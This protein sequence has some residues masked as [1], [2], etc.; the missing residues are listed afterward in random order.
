L[1]VDRL[2][3]AISPHKHVGED[4]SI[5]LL[6]PASPVED[7]PWR[8][9]TF[10][11]CCYDN[12]V[13]NADIAIHADSHLIEVL[14]KVRWRRM[15]GRKGNVLRFRNKVARWKRMDKVGGKNA[16]KYRRVML[17]CQPLILQR[18]E[19]GA[20]L[21]GEYGF[22][23]AAADWS[24]TRITQSPKLSK[25]RRDS[26]YHSRN[27]ANPRVIASSELPANSRRFNDLTF[28]LSRRSHM[29]KEHCA[30]TS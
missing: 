17:I 8:A 10:L 21:F 7:S 27:L 2:P 30:P 19:R 15:R 24:P 28:Y 23:L 6:I 4:R 11:T 3:A 26:S 12:A 29:A 20:I 9:R 18:D 13:D 25:T 22:V 16:F 1:G 14:L 5:Y